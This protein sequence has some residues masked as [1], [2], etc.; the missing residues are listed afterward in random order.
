M[1]RRPTHVRGALYSGVVSVVWLV[2]AWRNPSLTY[3]F[4]PL[5]GAAL[6]PLS[7]RS[8]GRRHITD[9]RIGGLGGFGM[10]MLVTVIL[11]I[12][13]RMNGPNFAHVGP[14]WPEAVLFAA[15]GAVIATRV[16]SRERP[17]LLGSIIDMTA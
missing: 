13:G 17:G 7:L 14:A 10:M 4:A 3:H 9:A 11:L 6:W 5:I 15:I 2:L 8:Q 12:T 1:L 16:A